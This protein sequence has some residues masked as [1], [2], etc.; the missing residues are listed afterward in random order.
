MSTVLFGIL[1]GCSNEEVPEEITV[2]STAPDFAIKDIEGKIVILSYFENQ[3]VVLRFFETDC[4]Y[5]R[6]DTPIINIYFEKYKDRGLKVFYIA[7]NHESKDTVLSF[8]KD[9][10]VPFPIIL[11]SE[12]KVADLYNVLLYPQTIMIAPGR[13]I[14]AIIPGGVG[15]AELDEMVGPYLQKVS[16]ISQ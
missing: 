11:D 15:E 14:L 7:A 16:D 12:A 3:P 2:G 4:K 5:C 9:L 10:D 6:A 13:K 1:S 8:I